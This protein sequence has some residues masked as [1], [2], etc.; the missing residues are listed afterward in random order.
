MFDYH[1]K[2]AVITGGARGIGRCI[3]EQFESAGAKVCVIDL[4]DN[5]YFVGDLA[6]KQTSSC[7]HHPGFRESK[8]ILEPFRNVTYSHYTTR[9]HNVS[10]RRDCLWYEQ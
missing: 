5:D 3:K 7:R 4:L 6:D 1:D 10:N 2:V 9:Y 8:T